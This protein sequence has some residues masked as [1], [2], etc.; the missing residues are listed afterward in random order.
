MKLNYFKNQ[1]VIDFNAQKSIVVK[2]NHIK[3]VIVEL[4]KKRGGTFVQDN[5]L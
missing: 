3:N 4:F 5:F 1:L 2:R